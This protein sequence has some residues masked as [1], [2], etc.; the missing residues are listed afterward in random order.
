MTSGEMTQD[1]KDIVARLRD[2]RSLHLT[3]LGGLFDEA[4][5]EIERLRLTD[6]ERKAV[7]WAVETWVCRPELKATLRGLLERLGGDK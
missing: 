4:A 7:E 1:T 5:D 6:A 2:W 3:R